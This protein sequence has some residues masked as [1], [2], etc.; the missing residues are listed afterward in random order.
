M[1]HPSYPVG[2]QQPGGPAYPAQQPAYPGQPSYPGGSD[3]GQPR[4]TDVS[5]STPFFWVIVLLPLT[6]LLIFTMVDLHAYLSDIM[7]VAEAGADPS[8]GAVPMMP[9]PP[10]LLIG[11]LISWAAYA[12]TVVLAFFDW[13][14]LRN[15]GIDRPFPWPW[16]FLSLVYVIGRSVV[17]KRRTGRGLAPLVVYIVVVVGVFVVSSAIVASAVGAVASTVSGS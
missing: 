2:D 11:Q 9:T 1:T 5:P 14:T 8:T 6:G 12:L 4:R 15:R 10:G 13:R 16:A 7:R 3:P 17:V